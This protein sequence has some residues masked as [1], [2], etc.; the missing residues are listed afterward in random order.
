MIR[1]LCRPARMLARWLY[2]VLAGVIV[3]IIWNSTTREDNAARATAARCGHG[4]SA[5]PLPRKAA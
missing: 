3:T 2:G 5:E 4:T 1:K